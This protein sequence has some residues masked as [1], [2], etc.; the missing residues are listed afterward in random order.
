MFSRT[1][2]ETLWI[3]KMKPKRNDFKQSTWT[4]SMRQADNIDFNET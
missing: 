1:Q 3:L 4:Y 2:G